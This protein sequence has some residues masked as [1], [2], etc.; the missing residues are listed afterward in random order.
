MRSWIPL[1]LLAQA[2]APGAHAASDCS[3][4]PVARSAQ[5]ILSVSADWSAR[6]TRI[7]RFSRDSLGRWSPVDPAPFAGV[8]GK[9][10]L[11][12]GIGLDQASRAPGQPIKQEGDRRSPAGAFAILEAFGSHAPAELGL[13]Q[14]RAL[15]YHVVTDRSFCPDDPKSKFYNHLVYDG[16]SVTKDWD[17]AENLLRPDGFEAAYEYALVI[18]HNRVNQGSGPSAKGGSCIFLHVWR[19]SR[20]GTAGCTAVPRERM[21]ELLS[22]LEGRAFPVL[23]QLPWAEY[24][25]LKGPWCLPEMG[26][27]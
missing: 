8:L 6:E 23:V 7:Q 14:S 16:E 20:S 26:P 21:K 15:L 9:S 1:V 4:S 11:G 27:E 2:L 13:D 22:W 24:A 12:W 5:L 10:G 3:A 17:S 18:G 19:D 25:R